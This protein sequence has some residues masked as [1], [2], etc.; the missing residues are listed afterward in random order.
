MLVNWRSLQTG[1]IQCIGETG[2][3]QWMLAKKHIELLST[4]GEMV[5]IG[6]QK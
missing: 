2:L 3:R 5:A 1:S 6:H 4:P